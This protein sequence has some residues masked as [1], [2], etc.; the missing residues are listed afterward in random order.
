MIPTNI[1]PSVVFDLLKR[2][3]WVIAA[4]ILLSFMAAFFLYTVLPKVYSAQTLILVESQ[5]VPEDYIRS[6]VTVDIDKRL[7]TIS[8]QVMSR[9]RLMKVIEDLSLYPKLLETQPLENVI[10]HVRDHIKVEVEGSGQHGMTSFAI[11]YEDSNPQIVAK[12]ANTLAS[13]FIEEN[14]KVREAQARGT[15]RFLKSELETLKKQ[16]EEQEAKIKEYKREHMGS[17]PEQLNANIS[18]L[19]RLQQE[20]SDVRVSLNA[21][22]DRRL[23]VQQQMTRATEPQVSS[24]GSVLSEDMLDSPMAARLLKLQAELNVL[25]SKYT[26]RHPDIIRLKSEIEKVKVLAEK[27]AE[28]SKAS[29]KKGGLGGGAMSPRGKLVEELRVENLTLDSELRR[30]ESKED[31]LKSQ[32]G[33][34]QRRVDE[35]PR[36]EQEFMGLKRDYDITM[37]NY[38][39]LLNRELEA[40]MAENL[41]KRQQGEQF[42]ILDPAVPPTAPLSPDMKKIFAACI[43]LGVMAGLGLALLLEFMDQSF[44]KTEMVVSELGLPV[45]ATIKFIPN[46][47]YKRTV[48]IKRVLACCFTVIM[49][50][51]YVYGMYLI[52][53]H[54][55]TLSSFLF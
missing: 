24:D 28:E 32:I 7:R 38:Q 45:L 55:Y 3:K 10:Q 26:D 14:L 29:R 51:A 4:P 33:E 19:D 12:V 22:K 39:S 17:L 40:K 41:E 1:T 21:T 9:T 5:R 35:T 27:E 53:D 20:L 47:T 42:T 44:R 6:T 31:E 25:R 11:S 16:L 34:Y 46:A 52:K 23:N 50:S 36:R 48:M 54:G 37:A 15:T 13:L 30:L 8:Q 18:T 2:R 49:I 43:G